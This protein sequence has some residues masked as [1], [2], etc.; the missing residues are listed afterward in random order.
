MYLFLVT[1]Y[2]SRKILGHCLSTNLG[3]EGSVIAL[4]QALG[5]IPHPEGMIHHSDRGYQYSSRAMIQLAQGHRLRLS[6]TEDDHVYE[7]AV[8][9]RVNGI[10]KDEFLLGETLASKAVAR[11]Q[12][13][14]AIEIYNNERPHTSL[15]NAM[16]SVKYQKMCQLF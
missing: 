1:H 7:N 5:Q 12:V 13:R 8:A 3:A 2:A 9:E 15:G 16:P 11:K 4:K 10:L 14:E 6:M